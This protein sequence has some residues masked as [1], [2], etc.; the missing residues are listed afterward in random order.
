MTERPAARPR[1]LG[2]LTGID[3]GPKEIGTRERYPY[4]PGDRIAGDLTVIGHLARGRFG[5]LYQVWS[6]DRWCAF[7]CKIMDPDQRGNREARA[8]FRREARILRRLHHPNIIRSF[9]RGEHAG[10]P[11][12]L[13]EYLEGASIFEVIERRPQRRL[14]LADAVRTAICIGSGLYHLHG[15]G[16]VHMDVKPA[17]VLLRDSVPVL[18]DFDVARRVRPA[19]RP[20]RLLGTAPYMAPEQVRHEPP[21]EATDVYGLGAVLYELVTGRWPFEAVY[22]GEE[23]R[24]GDER[25]YPQLGDRPPS[26][27]SRFNAR[28]PAS[29]D[30]TIIRCLE[31]D[32]ER[33]F[34]SMHPALLRLVDELEEPAAFW[35]SGIQTERRRR[36]RAS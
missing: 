5:H 6:A 22:D 15:H 10:L 19:R 14:G 26:P 34:P 12:L 3:A 9:D 11:Y 2:L 25:L 21:T 13:M 29:L 28:V 17:N 36:P 4:A 30:Q 33:R 20:R 1:R 24:S 32:P 23:R 8:A 31:P 27:P 35:P 16:Y 7:T 18:V